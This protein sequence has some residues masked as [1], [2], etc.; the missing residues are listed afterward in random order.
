VRAALLAALL[1][2]A[3]CGGDNAALRYPEPRVSGGTVAF[4]GCGYK[5]GFPNSPAPY[6]ASLDDLMKDYGSRVKRSEILQQAGFRNDTGDAR[7]FALCSCMKYSLEAGADRAE[8][9][10][11]LQRS[12]RELATVTAAPAQFELGT[13]MGRLATFDFRLRDGTGVVAKVNFA[14]NC[15][16]AVIGLTPPG[17]SDAAARAFVA[18]LT[19]F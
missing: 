2:M 15:A 11:M 17:R 7:Q 4:E 12:L 13:P 14:G 16:G 8:A 6:A 18:S 5:V 10:G 9:T 3:G 19:S 1:L